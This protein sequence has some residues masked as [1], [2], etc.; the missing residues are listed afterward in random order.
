MLFNAAIHNDPGL[1][2][3]HEL[4]GIGLNEKENLVHAMDLQRMPYISRYGDSIFRGIDS[5]LLLLNSDAALAADAYDREFHGCKEVPY[6]EEICQIMA[7]PRD[8]NQAKIQPLLAQLPEQIRDQI[9]STAYTYIE[10]HIDSFPD[11]LQNFT[12]VRK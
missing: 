5:E 12:S 11:L 10:K 6:P 8:K 9:L 4:F 7:G 2:F 3:G 1:T